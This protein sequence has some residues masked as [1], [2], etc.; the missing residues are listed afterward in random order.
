[1]Y[2]K[3][4]NRTSQLW[5]CPFDTRSWPIFQTQPSNTGDWRRIL[6]W[7][8]L[9][10]YIMNYRWAVWYSWLWLPL[11]TN[12]TSQL[13]GGA[14]ECTVVCVVHARQCC[15]R[16][17]EALL[18]NMRWSLWMGL[19]WYFKSSS[20]LFVVAEI[21]KC[22]CFHVCLYPLFS[23][24]E[25]VHAFCMS[26]NNVK[27]RVRVPQPV[28]PRSHS[29]I[30]PA[31]TVPD[32]PMLFL[33]CQDTIGLFSR[34][35]SVPCISKLPHQWLANAVSLINAH[36]LGYLQFLAACWQIELQAPSSGHVA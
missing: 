30:V 29:N 19:W 35:A 8:C 22:V 2:L 27:R 4:Q 28:S 20:L 13:C 25:L 17:L 11:H 10:K 15:K 6:R 33:A 32:N 14:F 7:F 23:W 16:R 34:L 5:N 9:H 1:M 18:R 31:K 12:C 26:S 21:E 24:A 3:W 36:L